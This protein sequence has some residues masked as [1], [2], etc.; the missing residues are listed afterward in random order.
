MK[1]IKQTSMSNLFF[2]KSF[3][4]NFMLLML[5][6]S[7]ISAYSLYRF[8]KET[9]E[10]IEARNWNLMYQIKTQADSMFQTIDIVS[11]F[12]SESASVNRTLQDAFLDEILSSQTTKQLHLLSQYLQSIIDSNEFAYSTYLYYDNEFGR[13]IATS[14]GL[15][16][17]HNYS[18]D[19]WLESY[20]NTPQ[21]FWYESKK[22]STYS[23]TPDK[24]VIAFYKKIYSPYSSTLPRGVLITYYSLDKF[25]EYISNFDLYQEQ[26]ILFLPQN[27][28]PLLQTSDEDFTDIW[29]QL[30]T[31]LTTQNDYFSFTLQYAGISYVVAGIKACKGDLYYLSLIPK[32]TLLLQ[33]RSLTLVFLSI[34]TASCVLSIILA[35][36]TA[37]REYNQLNE[38]IDI[39]NDVENNISIHKKEAKKTSDP[40]QMILRNIINLFLQ[41]QYLKLQIDNK[42][43]QLQLLKL[44]ALQNQINPH[45]LFNTLNTIYWEAISFTN[46]PNTCSEM[47]SDLSEIMAYSLTDAYEKVP[48][49]KELSYL[50]HY[51]NIQQARYQQNFKVIWDI[52][53]QVNEISVIKM[54]LQPL[55]ENSIQHGLKKNP[56]QG[57]I[58]IKIYH[59]NHQINFHILDNG[60]G[61]PND[62]LAALRQQL[63]DVAENPDHLGLLNTNRRLVLTYGKSSSIRLY[64][65]YHVGTIVSFSIPL[66]INE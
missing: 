51:V 61:I 7:I 50:Q 58:K 53:E 24:D 27:G 34:A 55:V 49:S 33:S 22:I 37:R 41:Q 28:S 20:K 56:E 57:I 12:L 43:Y 38:I 64:S 11:S 16:Y 17:I 13:Y 18:N 8:N 35:M 36:R 42:Q 54:L 59:Q 3:F 15:S 60:Q 21:D 48:I 30:D 66:K 62:K 19:N 10:T 6:L 1:K 46:K 52:D 45:F 26:I 31:K 29:S 63:Q 2:L 5:P 65:R 47:I 40:Y 32:D 44:Q 9:T 14:N 4:K 25:L 23:L 39:F